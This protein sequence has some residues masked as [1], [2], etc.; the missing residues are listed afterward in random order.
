MFLVAIMKLHLALAL[1]PLLAGALA[2]APEAR[3]KKDPCFKGFT[4]IPG[5]TSLCSNAVRPTTT[6]TVPTS[7][8]TTVTSTM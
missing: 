8:V 1:S 7:I 4:D 3:C 5:I 2:G 6:V